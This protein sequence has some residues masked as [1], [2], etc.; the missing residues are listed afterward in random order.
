MF[1]IITFFL[2]SNS[3]PVSDAKPF[4]IPQ[5]DHRE[6]FTSADPL[7]PIQNAVAAAAAAAAASSRKVTR[8]EFLDTYS[9][10]A[11]SNRV[12][13][14]K[15][16]AR[17]IRPLQACR[18]DLTE[19][20]QPTDR[21]NYIWTNGRDYYVGMGAED[22][23]LQHL[24]ITAIDTS[25]TSSNPRPNISYR[26]PTTRKY[27]TFSK[28]LTA[29]GKIGLI[30]LDQPMVTAGEALYIEALAF[31][32]LVDLNLI[33]TLNVQAPMPYL[34]YF[35]TSEQLK[36]AKL[37]VLGLLAKSDH[38]QT[39][40]QEAAETLAA[41]SIVKFKESDY[42]NDKHIFAKDIVIWITSQRA[43][44]VPTCF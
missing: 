17:Q 33:P 24:Q 38:R 29:G 11:S 12:V 32:V 16:S 3:D 23:P 26:Q 22:R 20:E 25:I 37:Y 6:A 36:T 8:Q 43:E 31:R 35:L 30:E 19:A 5:K 1:L 42:Y 4:E 10:Y 15:K 28:S 13:I 21:L 44:K 27:H 2:L 14:V 40:D 34:E 41:A 18:E 39:F 9:S 7:L